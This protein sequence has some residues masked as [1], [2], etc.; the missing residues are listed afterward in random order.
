MVAVVDRVEL[1]LLLGMIATVLVGAIGAA[2][3]P[4]ITD[5]VQIA[6]MIFTAVTLQFLIVDRISG[7]IH[8]RLDFLNKQAL[9][10]ILS[11]ARS[12]LG[13]DADYQAEAYARYEGLL[14]RYGKFVGVKLYPSDALTN[15]ETIRSDLLAYD[16][17][18]NQIFD[19]AKESFGPKYSATGPLFVALE[20]IPKGNHSDENVIIHK[21]FL[22]SLKEK[23]PGLQEKFVKS[24]KNT[25]S[26]IHDLK[27]KMEVFYLENQLEEA[28]ERGDFG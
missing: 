22:D 17:L 16:K 20:L 5:R 23:E 26:A 13:W 27:E 9:T 6:S 11:A 10:P 1:L 25:S 8:R 15:L 7:S 18:Y 19:L 2:Y 21:A 12:P 3:T 24:Y 14:K 4:T 28:K